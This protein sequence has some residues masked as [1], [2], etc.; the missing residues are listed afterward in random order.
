MVTFMCA[1]CSIPLPGQGA[2]P[3]LYVLTPKSTFPDD[4]PRVNWQLLVDTPISPAGL[5]TARIAMNDEE[6]N[7]QE[8]IIEV[9]DP[10]IPVISVSPSEP[11]TGEDVFVNVQIFNYMGGEHEYRILLDGLIVLNGT[12]SDSS[13]LY[14]PIGH[15]TVGEHTIGIQ[16]KNSGDITKF[17]NWTFITLW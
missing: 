7:E 3:R 17:A 9:E 2:P 1:G 5:S 16:I 4:V 13:N 10:P 15:T 12:I 11:L 14:L 8:L 6:I